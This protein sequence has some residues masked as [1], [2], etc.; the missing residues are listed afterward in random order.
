M[1]QMSFGHSQ[2]PVQPRG[3]AGHVCCAQG[4]GCLIF[5][6]GINDITDLMNLFDGNEDLLLVPIHSDVP[7]EE[8]RMAMVQ[9]SRTRSRSSSPPTLLRAPSPSLTATP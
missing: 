1:T 2:V 8:Q 3:G 6:S 7:Y 4:T 5:V 9:T